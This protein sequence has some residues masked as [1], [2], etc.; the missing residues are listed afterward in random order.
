MSNFIEK[1]TLNS[2][3]TPFSSN[4]SIFFWS[5]EKLEKI[6]L[7]Y[8]DDNRWNNIKVNCIL[9]NNWWWKSSLFHYFLQDKKYYNNFWINYDKTWLLLDDFDKLSYNIDD[10]I[11]KDLFDWWYNELF[12][13][14]HYFF[15]PLNNIDKKI[16]NENISKFI[17][18]NSNFYL[19]L[20]IK[21][22]SNILL[23]HN[24]QKIINIDTYISILNNLKS[25]YDL[26]KGKDNKEIIWCFIYNI[27]MFLYN[28]NDQD[29]EFD[30]DEKFI[31]NIIFFLNDKNKKH[32]L[33]INQLI[34][35]E[36]YKFKEYSNIS[37]IKID[38]NKN[39]KEYKRL[40]CY[41]FDF[42][43][44]FKSN[45]RSSIVE[46]FYLDLS[47]WEKIMLT[48]FITIYMNI[49]ELN[50]NEWKKDFIVL[51]DEPDLHLHLDCQKKYI[52][53]LLDFFSGLLDKY[54]IHFILAT[55]TPFIVSD[56]PW[57]SIIKFE[58]IDRKTSVLTYD[59]KLH[60]EFINISDYN[61]YFN[62][63]DLKTT[64][65]AN[66]LDIV[67]S[68]FFFWNWSMIWELSEKIIWKVA[69]LRRE[70]I[71]K[72]IDINN[73]EEIEKIESMIWDKFLANNLLYFKPSK[74]EK[75]S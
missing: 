33:L 52:K 34:N 68:W 63:N 72:E 13:D 23:E 43:L 40:L 75:S 49:I 25:I 56:L 51:I 45:T 44:S 21:K 53:Y 10:S 42:D 69:E 18:I 28:K 54:N 58:S 19:K 70:E 37:N 15:D 38:L 1:I 20:K 41:I 60:N 67:K 9:S 39:L 27:C 55:H 36:S 22:I 57:E 31:R 2:D 61:N 62:S 30:L 24:Y 50:E 73:I 5:N 14:I 12:L 74:N 7:L 6:L 64:F 3:V 48:R 11:H 59:G 29:D 8:F 4:Q 47:S 16:L 46:K 35:I 26:I 65:A 32:K 17:N 71:T 66:Y